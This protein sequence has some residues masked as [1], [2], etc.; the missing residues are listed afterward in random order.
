M[1]GA[2][3]GNRNAKK[4]KE[5]QLAIKRALAHHSK[6]SATAGLEMIAKKLVIAADKGD[7][8]AIKEI[9]ERFDGK[10]AQSVTVSGDEENPLVTR[11]TR[12][13]VYPENKDG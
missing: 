11:V 1:A 5:W 10:A 7:Q 9:G 2:P 8:W 12:E 6:D 3:E 4:G 13:I